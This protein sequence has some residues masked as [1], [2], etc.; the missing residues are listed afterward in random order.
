MQSLHRA[1]TRLVGERTAL[2]NQLRAVLLERGIGSRRGGASWATSRLY[3]TEKVHCP[4]VHAF[5]CSSRTC[6]RNGATGPAD[7]G[8]R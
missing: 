2:I 5:G 3:W 6:A 8:V 7:R 1:R 4:S